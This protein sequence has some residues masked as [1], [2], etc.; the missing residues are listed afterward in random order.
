MTPSPDLYGR[1]RLDLRVHNVPVD[2][3]SAIMSAWVGTNRD[4]AVTLADL[5]ADVQAQILEVEASPVTVTPPV[6]LNYRLGDTFC[7]DMEPADA[8][9]IRDAYVDA[10]TDAAGWDDLPADIQAKV[11]DVEQLPRTAWDD[12]ADVPD[13]TSHMD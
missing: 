8:D 4:A 3:E 12:P 2:T 10:G 1:I 11:L 9:M 6:W 7:R 13:D 5:P